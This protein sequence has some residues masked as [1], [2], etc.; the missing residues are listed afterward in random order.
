MNDFNFQPGQGS[1][2]QEQWGT[3]SGPPERGDELKF[4]PPEYVAKLHHGVVIVLA[5]VL[6]SIVASFAT[7]GLS[8]A[9]AIASWQSGSLQIALLFLMT[10]L[11]MASAYGWWIFGSP[12]PDGRL[13]PTGELARKIIRVVVLL[14]VLA[15]CVSAVYT[16]LNPPTPLTMPAPGRPPSVGSTI[17]PALLTQI[18]IAIVSLVIAAWMYF[19]QILYV[20]WLAPRLPDAY[21]FE[22]AKLLLW[23][24]PLLTI[25]GVL[26]AGLG[27]LIALVLHWNLL[28]RV[29]KDLKRIRTEMAVG[30]SIPG[31]VV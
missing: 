11:S 30:G 8:F 22:R 6:A 26:C 5:M 25:V 15:S 31:S 20:R 10:L 9:A 18:G 23:L 21:V 24:V 27:P 12:D 17:T 16:L 19:V 4:S 2:M 7:I 28:D 1:Q 13:H 14:S 29:R 3:A